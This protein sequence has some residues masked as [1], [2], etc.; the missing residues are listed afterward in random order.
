MDAKT[1]KPSYGIAIVGKRCINC[2]KYFQYYCTRNEGK[3]TLHTA[4]DCGYCGQHSRNTRP[5]N[6]C[7]EFEEKGAV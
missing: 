6:R 3:I 1:L 7:K 2:A 5:G 4:V